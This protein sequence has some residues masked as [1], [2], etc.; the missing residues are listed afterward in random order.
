MI[1]TSLADCVLV[2][3]SNHVFDFAAVNEIANNTE[4]T[5]QPDRPP[6]EKI[7]DTEQGKIGE[8]IVECYINSQ[9]R[10][11][12]ST[13]P[14][15][16]IRNDSFKKHAPF[17]FLIWN[18]NETVIASV[19]DLIRSDILK[20]RGKYVRL[21]GATRNFCERNNVKIV[22]VKS[23]QISSKKMEDAGFN[24]NYTDIVAVERLVKEIKER[25][26]VFCYPFFK[27]SDNE[28]TIHSF[29]DYC[30]YAKEKEDELSSFTGEALLSRVI[31][32]ER[33]KQQCN[34]FFRVYLDLQNEKAIII[35]WTIRERLLDR[36][37]MLK[38]MQKK[39]KSEKALYLAKSLIETYYPWRI[40]FVLEPYNPVFLP[41][42]D[43]R[44]YHK[45]A[46]CRC[47]PIGYGQLVECWNERET[48]LIYPH[49][50][51]CVYCFGNTQVT[52]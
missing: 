10:D 6:T 11:V 19:R 36:N 5:W 51:R 50:Q 24:G 7:H 2:D 30:K 35:G 13:L 15:D 39:G 28:N 18:G 8:E 27:R 31:E 12:L 43:T 45:M 32:L 23:T 17:D 47:I 42:C 16:Q 29:S 4:E 49:S 37:V 46:T 48:Q 40:Q 34:V 38:H 44:V 33:N 20:T 21:S 22:E 52:P 25:D 1:I 9:F 41:L 26:D 14:Y 3:Y